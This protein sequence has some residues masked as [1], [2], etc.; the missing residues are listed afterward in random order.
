[1]SHQR[2]GTDSWNALLWMIRFSC[3]LDNMVDHSS[4]AAA[5][6]V[7]YERDVQ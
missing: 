2:N 4:W 1:M 7:K 5:T 6:P 3:I